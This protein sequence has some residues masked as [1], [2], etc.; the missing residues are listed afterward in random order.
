MF[1]ALF[2]PSELPQDIQ[3]YLLIFIVGPSISR[4]SFLLCVIKEWKKLG[5]DKRCCLSYN[6]FQ[7]A[8]LN[9]IGSSKNKIFNIHDQISIKLLNYL[10]G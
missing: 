7:K 5:L 9:F 1:T 4:N 3:I 8:L 2:H 10:S 6:S